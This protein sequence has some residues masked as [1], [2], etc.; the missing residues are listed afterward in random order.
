MHRIITVIAALAALGLGGCSN[1][2]SRDSGTSQAGE[3][4]DASSMDVVIE[5]PA[6]NINDGLDTTSIA[7]TV[8][9]P[10]HIEGETYPV[11]LH[12]AYLAGSRISQGDLDAADPTPPFSADNYADLHD[13][14][15]ETLWQ[16]GYAVISLD[17]RGHGRL[18]SAA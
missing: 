6:P 1:N 9:I 4:V 18:G 14:Q 8:F 17:Q 15:I 5:S 11:I 10:E 3:R 7:A 13:L 16:A 2:D 12:A